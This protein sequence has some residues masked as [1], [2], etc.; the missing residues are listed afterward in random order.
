MLSL[1]GDEESRSLGEYIKNSH[2]LQNSK[3][4]N[5]ESKNEIE[6][7]FWLWARHLAFAHAEEF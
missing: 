6:L 1:L 5:S 4:P 3:T 2:N 7:N